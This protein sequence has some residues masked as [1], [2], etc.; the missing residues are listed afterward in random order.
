[1]DFSPVIAPLWGTLGWLVPLA[2]LIGLLKSP[3]AKGYVG[4]LL[5]R[6]FAHWQLDK[7]IY[8]RL[9]NVT[10]NT[11]D[12]TTQIDHV[13]LSPYGIFVLE[14]K[15]MSGWIFGSEKQAQWTQK[16]YKRTYKF[17]N[18]LR[19]NYKHL[20]A[21]EASLNIAPDHLHSVITFVGGSTFKTEVPACV[22]QGI[23]FIRYI[24]SFQQP[25]FSETEVDAML[26]ALQTGRR[27]PSFATH[28]EHV[29][30]LKRRSDPTAERQ[31]PKCGSTLVIRT[32]KSGPKAGQQFWGCLGYPRC[33]MMQSL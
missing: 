32:V 26:K 22:T 8:R 25:V 13:F 6:L 24:K 5:V 33:R 16:I 1:M 29:Q 15:S 23:G 14:T 7:L 30:N 12:G 9:H 3:W 11:P 27:A 18:P 10:L 19:Q 2:L 20:K 31:C 4:E 17:Q 28:R 21:L